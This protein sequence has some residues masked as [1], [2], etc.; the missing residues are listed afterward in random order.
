MPRH[1]VAWLLSPPEGSYLTHTH[2]HT[3]TYTKRERETGQE[4]DVDE[5]AY[6]AR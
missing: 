5:G 6:V 3:H 2:T 4:E 1:G